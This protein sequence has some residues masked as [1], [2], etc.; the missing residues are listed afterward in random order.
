MLIC[1]CK[2]RSSLLICLVLPQILALS[3]VLTFVFFFALHDCCG[4]RLH[5]QTALLTSHLPCP[6]PN[7]R[8]LNCLDL[9]IFFFLRYMIVAVL[10]CMS[11][12]R[13]SLLI[14]LVL[15]QILALSTVLTFVFFFLRY[16]IVAVLIC[17][18]KLRSSLL[19]CLV[20]PQILAFST[21]LTFVF[22]FC[23]T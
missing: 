7:T 17:M 18:S 9:C 3:T 15:P 5:E 14:C 22:F 21:V 12:L 4:A 6:S 2:L 8:I 1:M 10:V 19:I 23:V 16:M 20:L 11:K 13:S